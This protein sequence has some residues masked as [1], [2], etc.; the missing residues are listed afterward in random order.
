M[1]QSENRYANFKAFKNKKVYNNNLHLNAYGYSN[2]W[3]DGLLFPD[4]ILNDLI[5]VFHPELKSKEN[6]SFYYYKHLN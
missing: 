6:T 5:Q 2:Y 4:R 3:E 1:L